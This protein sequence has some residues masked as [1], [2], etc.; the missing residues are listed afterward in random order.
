[1]GKTILP[2]GEEIST[3]PDRILKYL[4]A[5]GL[6]QLLRQERLR[7]NL[8]T[9]K[10]VDYYDNTRLFKYTGESH[11]EG[12][13]QRLEIRTFPDN[14]ANPGY[15]G[16]NN[17]SGVFGL[18]HNIFSWD[19][20]VSEESKS[21]IVNRTSIG[22]IAK[23]KNKKGY[24]LGDNNKMSKS[25]DNRSAMIVCDPFDGRAYLLSNDSPNYV[26]NET[27]R[28]DEKIPGRSL[29]R[30]IDIPTRITQ[31]HNDLSF[32]SDP[33]YTHSDNNFTNSNRYILDNIDDRTFV[34]P[35][36]S[37]D[38]NGGD[39]VENDRI[40]LNGENDY[41]ESDGNVTKM[42]QPDLGVNPDLG[43][44]GDRFGEA[45]SSYNK[46]INFSGVGHKKGYLPGIFRSVEELERVDLVDQ[47]MTPRSHKNTPGAKRGNNYYTNDGL[48][49]S[50]WFDKSI[51]D[52]YLKPSLNP[53]DM[54]TLN[55]ELEPVPFAGLDT[56]GD[57]FSLSK[58]YQWRYNRVTIKYLA[59]DIYCYILKGGEE[60]QIGDI[61]YWSFLDD[62]FEYEVQMV[63]ASGE[64]LQGEFRVEEGKVY[65]QDPS[66]HGVGVSFFNKT[67]LG[68]G[69]KIVINTK[70][71]IE[72]NATQIKNNL[73]AYVDITPTVRSDNSTPWSDTKISD[74][75]NGKITIRSTAA[76]PGFTGIN[77]GKGGPSINDLNSTTKFYEHGGNAT[78]GVH[79]HLFRYV[80]DTENPTYVIRDGIKVYTGKWVDQGPMG[81]ERPCDIKALF[82]SNPDTNNFNN[83][84]KFM[85]DTLF[86]S[87]QNNPDAVVTNNKNSVSNAYIHY[88]Q[89]DPKS[90]Q[91]FTETRIDPDSNEV[92]EVD[93]TNKVL[94]VNM[95][96]GMLFM[97]NQS[98]K[99][100]TKYGHGIK[101]PGWVPLA[102][103]TTL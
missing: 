34:Y 42:N 96:T 19:N 51:K 37:R 86:D 26:N 99:S 87:Y 54:E 13:Y 14:G 74:D 48:W 60:Y 47:L 78:A 82:L 20:A 95:A 67:G 72:T 100:D 71:T 50:N 76:G 63:G 3:S 80:I 8:K 90:D 81:V 70:A 39:F 11:N 62:S 97:Y 101:S 40:G 38:K 28:S 85:L 5:D 6:R 94:Y 21:S 10:D 29:A 30:L 102:G 52:S 45:L 58:L 61:L 23:I 49:N 98:Y 43:K 64:I 73:Y 44:Y 83:Y 33:D 69:A 4:N 9:N 59:K 75:Q 68:R 65:N 57:P 103:A 25:T 15:A 18:P 79:V 56:N 16:I 53:I 88:D 31:L 91:K 77:S 92:I 32:V 36:I 17:D 66:T 24:G 12:K 46:N 89:E 84:Y 7:W 41:G 22:A 1:M 55:N 2:S 27:R 35:E 93:I